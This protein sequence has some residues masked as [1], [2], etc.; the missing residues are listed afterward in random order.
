MKLFFS[1][2]VHIVY[3]FLSSSQ[4]KGCTQY[5]RDI[6]Q[7]P[8]ADL[9]EGTVRFLPARDGKCAISKEDHC[10]WSRGG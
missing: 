3:Q 2:L 5:P 4:L 7:G 8:K 6:V 10:A 9:Q 1:F